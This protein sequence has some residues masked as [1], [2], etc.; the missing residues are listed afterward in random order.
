MVILDNIRE[1]IVR[2]RS[3]VK[4]IVGVTCTIFMLLWVVYRFVSI[5]M[6]GR[7]N[8]FNNARDAT[9]N[10]VAVETMEVHSSNG[11][12]RQPLF[13]KSNRSYVSGTRVGA[14]MVDQ[15]VGDGKIISV[16]NSIDYDTG[17]YVIKT[18]GVADGANFAEQNATGFFV[19]IYAI[20]DDSV[21]VVEDGVVQRRDIKITRQD[22]DNALVVDGL[23][24]GD[25]VILSRVS[26][27]QK[28]KIK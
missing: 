21:M 23:R 9:T 7:M 14:F 15:R 27:G 11:I 28:V 12:L 3:R 25:I 19:P 6:E 18:S 2:N 13:V 26:V 1:Y 24:E 20:E 8:V 5:A 22:A 4:H 10:G 17:M 16:S